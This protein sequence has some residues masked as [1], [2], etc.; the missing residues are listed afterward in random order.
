MTPTQARH[1]RRAV[2]QA[3]VT[4][5]AARA[6]GDPD[7]F[8][9]ADDEGLAAVRAAHPERLAAAVDA[10]R[11]TEGR[12]LDTFTTQ[13]QDEASTNPDSSRK[14]GPRALALRTAAEN[15]RLRTLAA[16]IHQIRA[17]RRA[18]AGWGVA[19]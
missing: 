18:R 9:C 14:G 12:Q 19:A 10:D 16:Q 3:A 11:D 2:P 4:A 5:S 7:L 6:G 17:A 1:V 8:F 13:L 15:D